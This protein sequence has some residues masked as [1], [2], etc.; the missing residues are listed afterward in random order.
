[1]ILILTLI[2][3]PLAAGLLLLCLPDLPRKKFHGLEHPKIALDNA[4]KY[5][6]VNEI[7]EDIIV[8]HMWP[9]TMVP[10]KYKES[11]IVSF[12]DKYLSSREFISEFRKRRNQRQEIRLQSPY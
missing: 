5:F 3:V 7:E 8:K 11:F 9:L 10:P 12:A 2:L 1:M 4:R 6:A